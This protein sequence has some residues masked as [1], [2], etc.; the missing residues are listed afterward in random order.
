MENQLYAIRYCSRWNA[1][2]GEHF[3]EQVER[4]D[5]SMPM[6]FFIWLIRTPHGD[7]VVDAGFHR[8]VA[9]SPVR[10]F[11]EDPPEILRAFGSDPSEVETV[12]LTHLHIDHTGYVRDFP[13]SRYV[14]QQREMEFWAGPHASRGQFS[15]FASSADIGYLAAANLEG[16]VLVIDGDA[17]IVPGVRV[18]LVGGHTQGSQVVSVDT[19]DGTF[20]LASDSSHFYANIEEDRPYR[21]VQ[22]TAEIYDAFARIRALA[23]DA[24]HVIPGHDPLV[25]DRYPESPGQ[26]LVRRIA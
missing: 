10:E 20:V 24:R 17:E 13:R 16:R 19:A 8:D 3:L 2:R 23:G 14:V 1:V 21:V 9:E 12:I 11:F 18:H 15:R 6:D 26:P 7:I 25:T 22:D 5:E 4:A